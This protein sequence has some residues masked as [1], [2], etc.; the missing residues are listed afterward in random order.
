[1]PQ[2]LPPR[3]YRRVPFVAPVRMEFDRFRGFVD[4]IS[5]DLSLGGMFI[6]NDVPPPVGSVVPIEFRLGDGYEL[7][8]GSGRVVWSRHEPAG[9][10]LPPGFGIRFLELTPGSRELIFR[11]V[12]RRVKEGGEAFELEDGALRPALGDET[13]E[14]LGTPPWERPNAG[15]PEDEQESRV[16]GRHG[17]DDGDEATGGEGGPTAAPEELYPPLYLREPATSPDPGASEPAGGDGPTAGPAFLALEEDPVAPSLEDDDAVALDAAQEEPGEPAWVPAEDTPGVATAP[18]VHALTPWLPPA[19]E[20]PAPTP[21]PEPEGE[22]G[23]PGDAG[24]GEDPWRRAGAFG[25]GWRDEPP[26]GGMDDDETPAGEA[27]S[28]PEEDEEP[29]GPV[30]GRT[31]WGALAAVAAVLVVL[32]G[33][34]GYLMLQRWG[35]ETEAAPAGTPLPPRPA[36]AVPDET[37]SPGAAAEGA[38]APGG[39]DAGAAAADPA[40]LPAVAPGATLRRIDRITWSGGEGA[41]DFLISGDGPIRSAAVDQFRLDGGQPRLVVRIRGVEAPFP[42]GD[43]DVGGAHVSRIRTGLHPGEAGRPPALHVVFDLSGAGIEAGPVEE[44]GGR[45][46]I[47]FEGR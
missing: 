2:H 25:D 17:L 21:D 32:L 10:D 43:L 1:M 14:G 35:G 7:I 22:P 42:A 41:S 40:V 12:E 38:T 23:P 15:P 33:G 44:V 11:L 4:E 26:V 20:E 45:L 24:R 29:P 34:G 5:G 18:A 3:I 16:F 6:R 8:R 31:R 36:P 13:E 37:A 19:G 47:R 46:R 27:Y 39:A 9:E 30:R 28:V